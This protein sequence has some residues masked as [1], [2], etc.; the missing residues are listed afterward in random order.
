MEWNQFLRWGWFYLIENKPL[1]NTHGMA[2]R[3]HS[4]TAMFVPLVLVGSPLSV[5]K[6]AER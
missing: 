1:T 4:I 2:V 5:E 6:D 3:L